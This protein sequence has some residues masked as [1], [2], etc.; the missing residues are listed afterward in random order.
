LVRWVPRG[1]RSQ[2]CA[3]LLG[4]ARYSICVKPGILGRSGI[5]RASGGGASEAGSWVCRSR[6]APRNLC[7]IDA[8]QSG[9]L[10]KEPKP[11]S[12]IPV[13]L[14]RKFEQRWAVRFV[15]SAESAAPQKQWPE[16]HNQPVTAPSKR[17]RKTRRLNPAGL[18]SLAVRVVDDPR[19]GQASAHRLKKASPPA[20]LN[21]S[22][23]ATPGGSTSFLAPR[24]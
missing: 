23:P 10:Q 6:R 4:P 3:A 9:A 20:R 22:T 11:M 24:D 8:F 7:R 18:E 15:T 13:H 1:N 21:F 19:C 16:R 17:T 2:P 5:E 14:Q 12:D